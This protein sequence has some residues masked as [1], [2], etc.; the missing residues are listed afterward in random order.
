MGNLPRKD[1]PK[2]SEALKLWSAHLFSKRFLRG[3]GMM[4]Q[5]PPMLTREKGKR[6]LAMVRGEKLSV[7]SGQLSVG[8]RFCR[9]TWIQKLN[10]QKR[11]TDN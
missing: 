10:F 6:K 2:T 11:T 9:S 1:E 3:R 4:F 8:D 5:S 7:V